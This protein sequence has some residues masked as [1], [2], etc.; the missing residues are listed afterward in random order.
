MCFCTLMC[1]VTL[2]E[3][4]QTFNTLSYFGTIVLTTVL[5]DPVRSI[6]TGDGGGDNNSR[7]K[8][9]K[10]HLLS[11]FWLTYPC[12]KD[13]I[14]TFRDIKNIACLLQRKPAPLFNID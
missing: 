5:A 7:T 1:T 10:L 3:Q 4:L 13:H 14:T 8:V 11:L 2:Q 12:Q 9:I 6:F